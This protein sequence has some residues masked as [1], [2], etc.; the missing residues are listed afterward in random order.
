MRELSEGDDGKAYN[1]MTKK[2]Y[3]GGEAVNSLRSSPTL[4]ARVCQN[5]GETFY[6]APYAKYCRKCRK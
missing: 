3:Q 6:Q 4:P 5:C 2:R 1:P